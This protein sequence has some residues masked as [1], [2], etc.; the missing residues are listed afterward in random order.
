MHPLA[1]TG[2]NRLQDQTDFPLDSLWLIVHT[3]VCPVSLAG[4][5]YDV[6][7][8]WFAIFLSDFIKELLLYPQ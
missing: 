8:R 2:K 6:C 1:V 7:V 3:F 4:F 5:L